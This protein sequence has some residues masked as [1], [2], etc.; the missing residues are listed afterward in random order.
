MKSRTQGHEMSW[1]KQ[2]AA[3]YNRERSQRTTEPG[4][5]FT[6]T[7]RGGQASQDPCPAGRATWRVLVESHGRPPV[8]FFLQQESHPVPRTPLC[9]L[10]PSSV[11]REPAIRVAGALVKPRTLTAPF[12]VLFFF[13]FRSGFKFYSV[14]QS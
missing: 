10:F 3:A 4:T 5:N 9:I 13:C 11:H 1:R 8:T 2:V 7:R 6:R 14:F 12:G